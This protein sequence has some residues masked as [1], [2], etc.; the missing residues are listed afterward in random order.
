MVLAYIPDGLTRKQIQK[1]RDLPP[2]TDL[3]GA[4]EAVGNGSAVTAMDTVPLCLWCVGQTFGSYSDALWLITSAGGD[5]DTT[6]AIVGGMAALM[7]SAVDY[8][9]NAIPQDWLAAREPLPEWPFSDSTQKQ[10]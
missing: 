1:A 2:E 10:N 7:V 3:R 4:V 9:T 8:P 5:Q 6:S